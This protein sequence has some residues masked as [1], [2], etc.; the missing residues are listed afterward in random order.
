[1]FPCSLFPKPRRSA[2]LSNAPV[3]EA[4]SGV[5]ATDDRSLSEPVLVDLFSPPRECC[6]SVDARLSAVLW[7]FFR[8][9]VN[10]LKPR[11]SGETQ[12]LCVIA[13]DATRTTESGEDRR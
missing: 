12:D 9:D 3:V 10:E 6:I 13:N 4:R 11:L 1:M 8:F 2:G 5:L 7:R